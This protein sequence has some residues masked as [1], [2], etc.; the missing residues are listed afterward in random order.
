MCFMLVEDIAHFLVECKEFGEGRR[1]LLEEVGNI[2]GAEGWVEEGWVVDVMERVLLMLGRGGE[3]LGGETLDSV[4]ICV[5]R[6]VGEWWRRRKVLMYAWGGIISF[7]F[8]S[9]Y[10]HHHLLYYIFIK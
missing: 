2:K 7:P 6:N 3:G 9:S 1:V 10:M 4:D 5:G 8:T